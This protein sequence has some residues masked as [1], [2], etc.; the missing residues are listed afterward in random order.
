MENIPEF[1]KRDNCINIF[2]AM[3]TVPRAIPGEREC[4]YGEMLL[5]I[6]IH[7]QENQS[8][9]WKLRILYLQF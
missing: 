1:E 8:V 9:K 2:V 4:V 5:L 7:L 3:V 6:V